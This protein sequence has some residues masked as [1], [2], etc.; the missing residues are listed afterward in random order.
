MIQ[1]IDPHTCC[2]CTA[3]A[4]ICPHKAIT[5]HPDAMGFLYPIVNTD[6][7]IDCGLCNRVCAFH[8]QYDVS[9]HLPVPQAYAARHKQMNHV[10]SSQS[11]AAF[12]AISNWIIEQ[13]G[14]IYGAGYTEHLHVA[15]LRAT[16]QEERDTLKRA[17][18]VQ[19]DLRGVFP[20]I[21]QDLMDGRLVLFTGTPCQCAGLHAYL[22]E[23]LQEKLYL[24]DLICHGVPS[25]RLWDDYVAYLEQKYGERL[26]SYNFRDKTFGWA[27]HH[28]TFTLRSQ[29]TQSI[30]SPQLFFKP[31]TLRYSCNA[32]PFANTRRPSDI[33]IGDFWGWQKV[34]PDMF[35]DNKGLSLML[36]NTERGQQLFKQ[37]KDQ[38]FV[39]QVPLQ[40]SLQPNLCQPTVVHPKRHK[41]EQDY[42]KHGL[43][44]VLTHNYYD[45]NV[46][47]RIL[48]WIKYKLK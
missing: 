1:I 39:K 30:D 42:A 37:I 28:E 6:K 2:G 25:P 32:C 5:M 11:G 12:V 19:S 10:M 4:S 38:M 15:H 45:K 33:T 17:K 40:E 23:K 7:C 43:E 26:C 27:S 3:C 18:Y 22:P 31:V 44:Y 48:N 35:P 41:F 36:I 21:K 14:I 47:Y 34:V 16:T 9:Q 29:P 24:V 13:D 46:L 8:A 20:L